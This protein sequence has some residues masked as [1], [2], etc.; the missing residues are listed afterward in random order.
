M[1]DLAYDVRQ[2]V[3]VCAFGDMLMKN[4]NFE[5]NELLDILVS[6]NLS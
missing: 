6:L 3:C 5:Q 2:S 4:G 1:L